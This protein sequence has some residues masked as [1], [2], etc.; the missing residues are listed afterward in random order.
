MNKIVKRVMTMFGAGAM[1][2]SLLAPVTEVSAA[3]KNQVVEIPVN[4]TN[5]SWEDDWDSTSKTDASL[6]NFGEPSSYS[7]SYT[8]SYKLYIPVSFLKQEA[9][10]NIGGALNFNEVSEDDWKYAGYSELPSVELHGDL[11][12]TTWDE[13]QQKDIPVDYATVKKTGDFYVISYK[14]SSGAIHAE[15]VPGDVATAQKVAV[16]VSISVK[17]IYITAK[18]SAVYVDDVQIAKADGTVLEKKDFTSARIADGECVIAPKNN[19]D[20]DTKK[21]KLAT[22]TDNKVLTV[23][24]TKATVK[25]GKTAKITATATPATKITY[26]S[27]NKKIA[28]VSSKGVITGKKAGKATISV[29]ANGKTV[30]VT[31]TVKK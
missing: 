25:V 14:A 29:K 15:D 21:L 7:E 28:T 22:I 6:W 18:N 20:K 12:L 27:S 3:S 4:F 23:K 1:A 10:V 24:S 31:V 17:G 19:W 30:K 13:A 11:S 26:A 5:S 16:D 2:L 8:V 9:A